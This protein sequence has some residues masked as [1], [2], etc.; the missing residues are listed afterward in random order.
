MLA[1]AACYQGPSAELACRLRCTDSC[2]AGLTCTNGLCVGA[3]GT[4]GSARDDAAGD[5]PAPTSCIAEVGLGYHHTCVLKTDHTVWCAGDNTYGQLGND[6]MT[7]SASEVQV[8]DDSGPITDATSVDVGGANDSS[9]SCALRTGGTVWCW[10]KGTDGALGNNAYTTTPHAVQVLV[11]S[12]L[13]PLAGVVELAVGGYSACARDSGGHAWCWGDGANGRLGDNQF[14]TR[15][16][17]ALVQDPS[18]QPFA[19]ITSLVQGRSHACLMAGAQIWCWGLNDVGRVGD[20]TFTDRGRPVM[21]ASGTSVSPGRS[22]TCA[23]HADGTASCWGWRYHDR[24][25]FAATQDTP[26]PTQ[27]TTS[28]GGAPLTG[29]ASVATGG[30]S[31]ARMMDGH[32]M[33]WG[34]NV[35]G[36]TGNGGGSTVPVVVTDRAGSPLANVDALTAGFAHV[37]AHTPA[38][39]LCWGRNQNGEFATGTLGANVGVPSP[40]GFSCP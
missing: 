25:G 4:C 13:A 21:V 27:V 17:A 20:G 40:L 35:H 18:G 1:L 22:H 2:P 38:G 30:V 31:C 7:A 24:L 16:T 8:R 9:L 36:Q 11:A 32:V 37:C 15:A 23:S 26:T 19:G 10:G 3:D 6:T 28:A 34:A 39:F 5:A 12:N 29:V 14:T 33:C